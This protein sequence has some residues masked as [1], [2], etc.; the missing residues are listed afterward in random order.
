M[1]HRFST[2]AYLSLLLLFIAGSWEWC[3]EMWRDFT[4]PERLMTALL[5]TVVIGG[6]L[7]WVLYPIVWEWA[8]YLLTITG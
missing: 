2:A 5:A 6:A 8:D 4:I 7:T 3:K 1:K